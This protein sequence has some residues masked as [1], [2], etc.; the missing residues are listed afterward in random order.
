MKNNRREQDREKEQLGSMDLSGLD[1]VHIALDSTTAGSLKM[2]LQSEIRGG[3][4]Q[5]FGFHDCLAYGPLADLENRK[6]WVRRLGWLG[7]MNGSERL[8]DDFLNHR[9]TS[10]VY[11]GRL[12]FRGVPRQMR[13]YE[14]R[15]LRARKAVEVV[16]QQKIPEFGTAEEL[17]QRQLDRYN[18]HDLEGF[19]NVYA[20]DA[21]LYNLL[22]GSLIAEGREAMR[23]RYRKRFEVDNVHAELVNRMV[24]GSRVIDHERITRKGSDEAV[25]AAAIYETRD[26]LIREVWFVYE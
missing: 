13:M 10:L 12:E 6:G 18:A 3:E 4:Y 24:I 19:L 15:P 11:A 1:L 20:E 7:E 25:S 21:K 23:E 14:V 26:A 9:L 16:E 17:A 5:V 22:D 2:V 8:D